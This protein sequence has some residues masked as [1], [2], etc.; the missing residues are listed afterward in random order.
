MRHV[1]Q[2]TKAELLSVQIGRNKLKSGKTPT[3]REMDLCNRY[4]E[5]ERLDREA[6]APTS[7]DT[8]KVGTADLA[9][10][11]GV[12]SKTIAEWTKLGMPKLAFA[13]Y[14]FRQVFPWWRDKIYKGP[15]DKDQTVT[16]AKRRYWLG[17]ADQIEVKTAALKGEYARKEDVRRVVS[18]TVSQFRNAARSWASRL[19]PILAGKTADEMLPL[20]RAE[21]DDALRSL[22]DAFLAGQEKPTKRRRT[23]AKRRMTTRRKTK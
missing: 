3:N 7:R 16:E 20:I 10:L 4:E 12:T 11:L 14:D 5:A 22:A 19:S 8:W 18:E 9:S 23:P 13:T 1:E 21:I 15:E 6:A 17:K 2:F